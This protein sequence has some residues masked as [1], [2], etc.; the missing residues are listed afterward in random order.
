MKARG[1]RTLDLEGL[2]TGKNRRDTDQEQWQP[3]VVRLSHVVL[4]VAGILPASGLGKGGARHAT[5]GG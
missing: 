2:R 5:I 4:V 1:S 3:N